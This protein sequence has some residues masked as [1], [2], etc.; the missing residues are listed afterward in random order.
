MANDDSLADA[1]IAS[2]ERTHERLWRLPLD[3]AYADQIKGDDSDLKNSG[4]TL[5]TPV[6]A[7]VFLKQ[8]VEDDVPW[9]HIDIAGTGRSMKA[10]PYRSRGAT[11]FGVRLLAD[12]LEGL[13]R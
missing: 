4:G 2:G 11:G 1:L 12:Y 5:A 10:L 8:F 13:D 6:T 7:A 3:E 9:A